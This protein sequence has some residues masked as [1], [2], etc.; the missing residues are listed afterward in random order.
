MGYLYLVWFFH[1]T[2]CCILLEFL[3]KQPGDDQPSLLKC[4]L[5]SLFSSPSSP[6]LPGACS[7]TPSSPFSTHTICSLR[8]GFS[9]VEVGVLEG[10]SLTDSVMTLVTTTNVQHCL[11]G[12][13][14]RRRSVARACT[15]AGCLLQILLKSVTREPWSPHLCCS[16][17]KPAWSVARFMHRYKLWHLF[18]PQR[19]LSF[20]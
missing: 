5:L 13:D 19:M 9:H 20:S 7:P 11:G 10:T 1:G 15:V 12:G 6:A 4:R 14:Q 2:N 3:P 17:V 8:V 18:L 16:Q